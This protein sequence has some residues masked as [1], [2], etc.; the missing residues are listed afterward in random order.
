MR[1]LTFFLAFFLFLLSFSTC[2]SSKNDVQFL[3]V[4]IDPTSQPKGSLMLSDLVEQVEYIPLETNDS[5]IVGN[6][7]NLD[8]SE[9]YMAVLVFQPQSQEVFLFDRTGRFIANIGSRGQGPYEY[10]SPGSVFIDESKKCIYVKDHR[11]LLMYDF[12]GK[13]L[14]SFSFDE[15]FTNFYA[16]I[17]NQ[18]ISGRRSEQ[19]DEEFY[20]YGIWDSTMNLIKRGVKGVPLESDRGYAGT[21][22]VTY[23]Y[24]YQGFPHLKESVLNDTVYLLNKNNEFKPKYNIN[25]GRYTMT[26]EDKGDVDNYRENVRNGKFIGGVSV[27]ETSN[28][29]FPRYFYRDKWIPCYYDKKTNQLLY[30]DS[31]EGIPDDY[32]GGVV[33]WPS[34][35][36][37]NELYKF[38]N[39]YELLNKYETQN[40][41]TPKGPSESVQK[42][43]SL[44]KNLDPEDNP[45]LI[46]AT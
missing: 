7:T 5:C 6:I 26:P 20:V 16:G 9:N 12:S 46:I 39:A 19:S 34:K 27:F 18:F 3:I 22:S 14:N 30:F 8:V 40:K 11:K 23:F 43:Q 42:L 36:K 13:Y 24:I 44:L 35:Q 41:L 21:G 2:K 32:T 4:N 38:I 29:L 15:S 1:K 31:E 10:V 17:D 28:F 37:N 25:F 33:F 45:V